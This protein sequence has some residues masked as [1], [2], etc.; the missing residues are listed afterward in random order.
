MA[1]QR[2]GSS[3]PWLTALPLLLFL[4][5]GC[6]ALP[7]HEPVPKEETGKVLVSGF[8][9]TVRFWSDEAPPN[10]D[11]IIERAFASYREANA[12]AFRQ[13]GE[14]PPL[15]LLALSGGGNDGA[16]GAGILNG[17]SEKG[18]RP[19]FALVTGIS[20]GALIAPLAFLGQEYDQELRD[21]FTK[22]NTDKILL[23]D[24]WTFLSGLTG[25]LSLTDSSPFAERI[26]QT[27]TPVLLDQIAAEHRKGRRLFIGTTNLEAQRGVI[28]NM[29]A[30]ANSSNPN[31]HELFHK[32]IQ[33]SAAIPGVFEP[34]FIDVEIG[35][36]RYSEIH[37]DGGVTS[38]VMLYP[39][40]LSRAA[41]NS[42]K[43]SKITRNLYII[44]NAKVSA[45]YAPLDPGLFAIGARSVETLIKNNGVGD[46]YRLYLGALEDGTTYYQ[47]HIPASFDRPSQE[48]FDPAYMSAL[49]ETGRELGYK[50]QSW[51]RAPPGLVPIG[52]GERPSG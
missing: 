30:I 22:T 21:L 1:Q 15:S 40:Q 23:A 7:L 5:T 35:G 31:R 13:K 42:F 45:E 43:T 51:D 18:S 32:V 46:L 49:F 41:V 28:W 33:A 47:I 37:V 52:K 48:L 4:L 17:W 3:R 10:A 12:D 50:A 27:Y 36:K 19:P 14:Y 8:D 11:E 9:K 38:Q 2:V 26:R 29:G 24:L 39:I 6:A 34:V 25:G 44:R 20:T 16:F